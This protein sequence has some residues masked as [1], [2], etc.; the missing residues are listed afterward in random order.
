MA[1]TPV[2]PVE[3]V[4]GVRVGDTLAGKYRIGRVVGRGGMGVVVEAEN[5]DLHE[6]VAVKFLLPEAK[7]DP[8]AVARFDREVR[9]AAKIKSEFVVR[10]F[11]AGRLPDGGQYMVLEY[12]DGEDLADRIRRDGPL[13]IGDA[14]RFVLQASLAVLEAHA[15]GIIHRDI[16][17]ANLRVVTRPDGGIIVKVL[18][19]GTYK[20]M[21][22]S[23]VMTEPHATR[24]G[25][26]VGTPMYA[27]PEQ[28]L[29]AP[30][31]D[32]RTDVWSL[33]ATLFELLAGIPP[34]G[35]ATFARVINAVLSTAAPPLGTLRTDVPSGLEQV[36]ARCLEKK[37]SDRYASVSELAIAL[38]ETTELDAELQGLL[39]RIV[40]QHRASLPPEARPE[41]P[42][43]GTHV[44]AGSPAASG[45][46]TVP[47]ADTV[48]Q[49]SASNHGAATTVRS[50][51]ADQASRNRGSKRRRLLTGAAVLAVAAGALLWWGWSGS[52]GV[53]ARVVS[54]PTSGPSRA[55]PRPTRSTEDRGT[56]QASS[57]KSGLVSS[58]RASATQPAVG[59]EPQREQQTARASRPG[60][61]AAGRTARTAG[62]SSI[63]TPAG[64]QASPSPT[65]ASVDSSPLD[66]SVERIRRLKALGQELGSAAE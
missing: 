53:P 22:G 9:V 6:R 62:N 14:V 1:D 43:S 66:P 39:E 48:A 49:A 29:S 31:V 10:V 11:D 47:S 17:P 38:G 37:P 35:G 42:R 54:E 45:Q 40:R 2:D 44:A 23:E 3:V 19:F 7:A 21:P 8:E 56:A 20:R 58:P 57:A 60:T 41:S 50:S 15:L 16:K 27:S 46:R 52:E 32:V 59:A 18:D 25:A 65:T 26:L 12:L 64:R 5:V 55:E 36:V 28:L 61:V 30:D 33:G 13:S 4:P 34:F 24:P 51:G 63:R